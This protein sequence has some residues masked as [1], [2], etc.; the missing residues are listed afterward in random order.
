MLTNPSQ[1]NHSKIAVALV[2]ALFVVT[3][4][5]GFFIGATWGIRKDLVGINGEV[6]ISK[7]IDLYSK[8]RSSEVSFNQ[9]WQVWQKVKQK[10][11][12]QPVDE[13]ELFYGA[14]EGMVAGLNDPYSIYF[15]PVE[16]KDFAE[17]LAGE[18]GGIGAEIGI[19]KEQLTIIAPLPES[20]AEKAGLKPG[21]K[22]YAVDGED[23]HGL[24]IEEAVAIIKGEKGTTVVLTIS[25]D[26]YDQIEEVTIVRDVIT[27]PT[28]HWEMMEDSIA[29]LRVSFINENTWDSFDKAVREIL[30]AAPKGMVFDLRSNPGGYLQTSV[31]IASEWVEEGL[32]V[33][34]KFSEQKV[35]E[36]K[37]RG[38]HRLVGMPTVVLVDKGSA[39]GAEIIAGA[40]QDY[41]VATL[42]GMQTFGKGSVQELE[43]LVDGS[44]LKLT[45]ARWFTP[46]DRQIDKEGIVPDEVI[47]EMFIKEESETEGEEV[48]YK[49]VGLEKALE[50]LK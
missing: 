24:T 36:Y 38:N 29:Y 23:T 15:P 21:D 37:S 18:F 25:H 41:G 42:V 46:K 40:L 19:R 4:G 5:F 30:Q 22:I 13:V 20:P 34:E 7:V 47:E 33:S 49:D 3:F 14:L 43:P 16:A 28:I 6:E 44:S 31:D 27:I 2:A 12:D 9:F 26:G 17:D 39:S 1:P 48:K 10:Y 50:I 35:N 11:V 45:V 32:I 8:S